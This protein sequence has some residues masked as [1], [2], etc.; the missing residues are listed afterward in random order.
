MEGEADVAVNKGGQNYVAAL[1]VCGLR[2]IT[3]L[4][5]AVH[6]GRGGRVTEERCTR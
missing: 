5:A 1:A 6:Y 4:T 2:V 3:P